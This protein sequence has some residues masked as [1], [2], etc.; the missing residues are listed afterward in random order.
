[1]MDAVR[2]PARVR[3]PAGRID[4]RRGAAHGAGARARGRRAVIYEGLA[5]LP[6]FNPDDDVEPLPGPVFELRAQV[7]A[8]AA[9]MFCTP[10]YAGAL[11]GSFKN[12]LDWSVGGGGDVREAGR[13]DQRVH[14]ALPRARLAAHGAR[15]H[16]RRDRRRRCV[17]TFPSRASR[18]APTG[19]SATPAFARRS[20]RR[21]AH[22]SS[23]SAR[24][25]PRRQPPV[26]RRFSSAA[27][28][29]P[30]VGGPAQAQT[31]LPAAQSTGVVR[32]GIQACRTQPSDT[33]PLAMRD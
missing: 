33:P 24:L 12:L 31:C 30:R 29:V 16:Q 18:S 3:E 25:S 19:S 17:S 4:Q 15:L 6:H 11:P 2:H 14:P 32:R 7:D 23:T 9:V 13:L 8:A 20:P 22:W 21:S 27:V 28:P 26:E 1:M 10:E 5:T